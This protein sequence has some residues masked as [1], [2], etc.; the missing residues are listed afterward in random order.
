MDFILFKMDKRP[1][2]KIWNSKILE[3]NTGKNTDDLGFGNEF[4]Y[5]TPK[6]QFVK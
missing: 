6:A 5:I 4:L 3:D 1:K 2:C